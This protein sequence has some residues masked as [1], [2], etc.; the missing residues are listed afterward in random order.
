M[1]AGLIPALR[2]GGLPNSE[3]WFITEMIPGSHPSDELEAAL[4]RVAINPPD[5]LREQLRADERGLLRAVNRILPPDETTDLVLI[6]D[7]FEELF[8]LVDDKAVRARFLDAIVTAVLDPRSRLRVIITLRADFTDRPLQYSDFGELLRHRTEFVLPLIPDE[9]EQAITGPTRRAGLALEA[10]LTAA[11]I[12]DIGDQP[13]MLPLL[14]YA[15]T[16]LFERREGRKLTLSAYRTSG[17]VSGALARRAD[18]LYAGLNDAGRQAVRQLFLRLVT[19]GESTEDTRRRVLRSEIA[20]LTADEQPLTAASLPSKPSEVSGQQSAAMGAVIAQFGKHRLL[21]FDRDPVTRG[22]TIEVAHEALIREWKRLRGW[23]AEDREF[24]LWGQRLRAALHQW[25]T[26]GRDE[27]ALLRGAPLTEA[28]G[29]F[30][31]R[32]TGLS[33][34]EQAFIQAG[35]G[36]R[37]QRAE[38][39]EQQRQRELEAAQK[40]AQTE[41]TRAEEHA[42]SAGRL[43]QRAVWLAGAL[44]IAAVLA[45]VAVIFGQ[46]ARTQESIAVSEAEQRAAAEAEALQRRDEALVQ[47][48]I[49]LASQAVLELQ[50]SSPERS[51]L[52]ALEALENYP[53][54]WQAERALSQAVTSSRL[55]RI[56]QH[57]AVVNAARWSADETRIL[58]ASDDG[59][60]KVWDAATGEEL[61]ALSANEDEVIDAEWSPDGFYI[62]T[63]NGDNAARIWNAGTGE[64]LAVLSHPD[65][66]VD[67]EWSPDGKR[68]VTAGK[69]GTAKVW[70]AKSGEEL[71]IFSGHTEWV[72]TVRWSPDGKRIVTASDDRTAKVWDAQTGKEQF[73]L[74]LNDWGVAALWSPDGSRVSTI[75]GDGL[76]KIW[77]TETDEEL[78]TLA[79]HTGEVSMAAW[80]PDGKRI[81]TVSE[82]D[83]AIIW[84]AQTGEKISTFTGH[85]SYVLW[86]DWSSDGKRIVTASSDG[87]ARIWDPETGKEKQVLYGHQSE[88]R[89]AFWSADDSYILTASIDGTAKLWITS[90]AL[91]SVTGLNG[92]A[93]FPAWSPE[94]DRIAAAFMDGI[95][96]IWQVSTEKE[97]LTM[98]KHDARINNVAWS[99]DGRYILASYNNEKDNLVMW[100]AVT[101]EEILTFAGHQDGT[102]LMSWSPDSTRIA[103]TSFDG[104]VK[105]WSAETGDNLLTFTGHKGR[106][107]ASAWSPDGAKIASTDWVGAAIIWDAQTGKEI[108]SLYPE[109]YGIEITGV[110]WSPDG[111]R[112]VTHAIDG[113]GKMWD[114]GTGEELLTFNGPTAWAVRWSKDG[115]QLLFAGGDSTIR[116]W[117]AGTGEEIRFYEAG[118]SAN[119]TWSPDETMIAAHIGPEIKIFP[120]WRSLD[121][122]MD[123]AHQCCVV[124]ELTDAERAQ[125]GL[126]AR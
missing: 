123:Y 109:D 86:A 31:R 107:F 30:T 117:N 37:E 84:D 88:V 113:I 11:I 67:V 32:Q 77:D 82:V 114:A 99:P 19:I 96:R 76:V 121:E 63:A 5:T 81:A 35:L 53:Y 60:A 36:L 18:E 62:V 110:V 20:S 61:T 22:P 97:L 102:F 47:A 124:C 93:H 118:G 57:K 68:I 115:K 59:T 38:E 13:G 1:K 43:R 49:G 120:A 101:G 24:L 103:S 4:L 3:K 42:Q 95:V 89:Q 27:G 55:R 12:N 21:T 122:L 73:T 51:V 28:E 87:S 58:T 126:P 41:K 78:F 92:W 79:G 44:V 105:V 45:V 15:L 39:R 52:L 64:M 14:Q 72:N 8:T 25:E 98:Q 90:P 85:N 56:F 125:F 111:K 74:P 26:S 100:N 40:L 46:N 119:V 116:A 91:F 16:E 71:L 17:G 106:T 94:G 10:G 34:T 66:V 6:I 23:L 65:L 48:S 75:S 112:L 54:T 33:Q 104:T 80:S 29:W 69:E 83:T 9:L 50:G 2:H 70:D 7:Q 108:R